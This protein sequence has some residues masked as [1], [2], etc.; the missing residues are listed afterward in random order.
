MK[1]GEK[2]T[3]LTAIEKYFINNMIFMSENIRIIFLQHENLKRYFLLEK[4]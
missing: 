4:T 1:T 2:M 3:H